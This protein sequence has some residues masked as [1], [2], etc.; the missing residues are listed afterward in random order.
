[1]CFAY[2]ALHALRDGYTVYG[3]IDAAG[4]STLDAHKYGIIRMLRAGVIPIT[5]ESLVSEWMMTGPI[6]KQASLSKK[7]IQSTVQCIGLQQVDISKR[8]L[9]ELFHYLNIS[10]IK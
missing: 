2:T 5:L 3:L 9:L 1:M 10:F 6:Q 4:D 7:Y 8:S